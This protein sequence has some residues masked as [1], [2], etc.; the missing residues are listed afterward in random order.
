MIN[1]YFI[2]VGCGV[3]Y[4]LAADDP[5]LRHLGMLLFVPA[6]TL[7]YALVQRNIRAERISALRLALQQLEDPA[8]PAPQPDDATPEA[9]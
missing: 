5:S 8:E 1:P 9:Q 6:A 7:L 2:G 4:F 3:L